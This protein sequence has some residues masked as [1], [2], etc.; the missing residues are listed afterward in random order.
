[1]ILSASRRT[2]IPNYYS[3]WF[4]KRIEEG[5]LYV[6][7]PYNFHQI[8]KIILSPEVIDCIVFWTKNPEHMMADLDKLKDYH[9]YFQFTL[10]GYGRDIEPNLPDKRTHLLPVFQRLAEKIGAER[11]IWR[12]DPILLNETYTW[13]Y[14]KKAFEEIAERLEG[15]ANRVV[16]SFLDIYD[17]IQQN[18]TALH[19]KKLTN[20]Q[21]QEL[22]GELAQIAVKHHMEISSCAEKLDL[23][24]VS[25][26]SCID[27]KRIEH[28]IGCELHGSRDRNQREACGCMES[29]EIGTYNTCFNG[30]KYCYANFSEAAVKKNAGLYDI[31]SPL[32]CGKT[33]ECDIITVRKMKSLR[34]EQLSLMI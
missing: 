30:C 17:K 7:N 25:H 16:I 2:D 24:G 31:N 18:M 15:A 21:M 3:E 4:Y 19:V 9:Y 6:R 22:A 27:K 8:S 28:I 23:P 5:F 10:T 34:E 32:L 26:G 12:Y 1:M 11:V 13:K 20:L 33:E 14:H 29:I